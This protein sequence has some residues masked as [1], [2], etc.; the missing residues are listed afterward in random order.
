MMSGRSCSRPSSYCYSH[1]ACGGLAVGSRDGASRTHFSAPVLRRG[2]VFALNTSDGCGYE[3]DNTYLLG[4]LSTCGTALAIWRGRPPDQK[5]NNRPPSTQ[6]GRTHTE[7]PC[8]AF[9][10]LTS[11][12]MYESLELCLAMSRSSLITM[13]DD[14]DWL[15]ERRA[16]GWSVERIRRELRTSAPKVRA[17][18]AA[19]G[20]P[21]KLPPTSPELYDNGWVRAQL[22]HITVTELSRQLGCSTRLVKDAARRA[23]VPPRRRQARPERLDDAAWL[24]QQLDVHSYD[25]IAN[26]LGRSMRMVA[27]A[28][29][30]HHLGDGAR[31]RQLHDEDWLRSALQTQS[32]AQIAQRLGCSPHTVQAAKRRLALSKGG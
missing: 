11:R 10:G 26:A 4:A 20:L 17:A 3:S 14:H 28:A 9:S 30:H 6:G 32:G 18:L 21:A 1:T 27:R 19:A 29:R 23:G 16:A 8:R 22:G 12:T 2:L 7:C 15:R 13:L 31:R 5:P 24:A 25:D